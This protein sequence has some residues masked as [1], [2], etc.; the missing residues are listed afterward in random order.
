MALRV[1]G[2][3]P[4]AP[5]MEEEL[6]EE[7]MPMEEPM[8][9]EEMQVEEEASME[10]PVSTG[11]VDPMIAGYK[12]PEAGPFMC[13]TCAHYTGQGTC[14]IVAGPIDEQGICNIFT[15]MATEE[16]EMPMEEMPAEEEAP[17]EEPPAEEPLPT[18]E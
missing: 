7:E 13:G 5:P 15:P 9:E 8:P 18:E 4:A 1:G 16:E 6:P 2:G 11:T 12:G 3:Q 17:V 10:E 14:A